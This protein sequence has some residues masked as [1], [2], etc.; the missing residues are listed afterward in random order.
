MW[1]RSEARGIP[2][3][4]KNERDMGHPG[5]LGYWSG[6]KRLRNGI[7][8]ATIASLSSPSR[9]RMSLQIKERLADRPTFPFGHKH[10]IR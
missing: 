8:S 1:F 5:V 10:A 3:L 2:H 6:T 4:A 9:P 7:R